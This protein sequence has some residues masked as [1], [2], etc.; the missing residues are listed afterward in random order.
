MNTKL[1]I[2]MGVILAVLLFRVMMG[3][4]NQQQ[5]TFY[6]N[7]LGMSSRLVPAAIMYFIFFGVG[8]FAGGLLFSGGG[9]SG[10]SQKGK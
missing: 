3:R 1:M 5:I 9:K 2:K 6:L 8:F 4:S 10:A 7:P